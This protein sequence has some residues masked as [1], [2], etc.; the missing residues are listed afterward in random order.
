MLHRQINETVCG[1]NFLNVHSLEF[2][3]HKIK[4][5]CSQKVGIEQ[6]KHRALNL[7]GCIFS[8]GDVVSSHCNNS[9]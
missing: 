4:L 7:L 5:M 2:Q 8:S 6:Q 3:T 9:Q 1:W